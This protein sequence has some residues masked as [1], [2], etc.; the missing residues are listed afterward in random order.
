MAEDDVMMLDTWE[1]IFLWIGKDANEVEKKESL[2]SA[3]KYLQ[4]DPSG[5]DKDIP[6]TTVKQGN[7]PLSFTGWFLAWDSNK[8]QD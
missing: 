7:E 6:I 3:K 2:V 4:T 1:Q 5:R 8:W